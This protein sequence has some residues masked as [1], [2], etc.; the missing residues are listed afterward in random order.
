MTYEVAI[1]F[2]EIGTHNPLNIF[3]I[4]MMWTEYFLWIVSTISF[5]SIQS[6]LINFEIVNISSS[7]F[8][9]K[10]SFMIERVSSF[11]SKCTNDKSLFF[12]KKHFYW[13]TKAIK[14]A[15]FWAFSMSLKSNVFRL[16]TK[17]WNLKT[18]EELIQGS[19]R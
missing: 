5:P 9:L 19:R 8:T 7:S 16:K 13:I 14:D 2:D 15:W 3:L 4:L 6:D 1:I 17:K 12:G 18:M 11:H 10:N